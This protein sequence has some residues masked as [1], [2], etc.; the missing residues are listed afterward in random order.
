MINTEAR[1]ES[2]L[3]AALRLPKQRR[4]D[5]LESL[6]ELR[7]LAE[8]A[9]AQVVGALT[10]ERRAP[11]PPL[12]FGKGKVEELRE[13]ARERNANLL[14]SDDDLTP[15]QERNLE[16]ALGLKVIDRTALILDIFAQR[17]R[18]SEG[19]LQVELAQLTYL[20]PRLVGQWKHLERLGGGIGT[21][22][23]GETQLESDRRLIRQR[24]RQIGE[25]L[26]HVETHRRLLRDRRRSGGLPVV[27]LVGYT[28][29]GKTTLLNRLAGSNFPAADQL[30]VTLDPAARLVAVPGHQP[31][32][33]TDTVGFIRKL[34][35]QLVS[36]FKATLEELREAN[37][38]LHVLDAS[39][40]S[41]PEHRD[42]VEQLLADL[43][44]AGRFSILALNKIDRLEGNNELRFLIEDSHGV[45]ISALTGQGIEELLDRIELALRPRLAYTILR[46]PYAD[47]ST[48]ALCYKTGRVLRRADEAGGIRLEVELPTHLLE[49]VAPYRIGVS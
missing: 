32:I 36:A 41:A 38:L 18:T 13:L 10:Q 17:A 39:H 19:K 7:H 2:A 16:A 43:G 31:F 12:Y 48:L 30:F 22:G 14:I 20:L 45:P 47:G 42:A 49:S 24:I 1:P 9:G 34:P 11:S 23:P 29:A 37:V 26:H 44:L 5:V 25:A 35:H 27:A 40:P 28:N 21:R 33:L 6:E 3:L 15:V 8:A 4:S 46:I